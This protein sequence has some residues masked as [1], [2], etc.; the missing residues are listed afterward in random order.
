M[1][2]VGMKWNGFF[3]TLVNDTLQQTL[4]VR[5]LSS[6]AQFL[7]LRQN[8]VATAFLARGNDSKYL[9]S[10]ALAQTRLNRATRGRDT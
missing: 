6:I 8:K 2:W 7:D 4:T 3:T 10:D 9:I 5:F 1:Y